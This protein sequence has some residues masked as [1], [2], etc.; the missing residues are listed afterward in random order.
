MYPIE[1][2][3]RPYLGKTDCTTSYWLDGQSVQNEEGLYLFLEWWYFHNYSSETSLISCIVW[4]FLINL[5][6]T[7]VMWLVV[8]S[9]TFSLSSHLSLLL[10]LYFDS[11]S[12]KQKLDKLLLIKLYWILMMYKFNCTRNST[13]RLQYSVVQVW[14]WIHRESWLQKSNLYLN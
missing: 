12:Y 14:V 4:I 9:T 1:E 8:K 11:F 6:L 2:L 5:W 10:C 7:I 3:D 13:N